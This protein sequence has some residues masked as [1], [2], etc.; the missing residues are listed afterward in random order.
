[1]VASPYQQRRVYYIPE[2]FNG[3]KGMAK[4]TLLLI[5]KL[6]TELIVTPLFPREIIFKV[7]CD[8]ANSF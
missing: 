4:V 6:T 5:Q 3:I 8:P 1:M 7:T 2:A